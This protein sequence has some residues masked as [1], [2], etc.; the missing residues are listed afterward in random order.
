MEEEDTKNTQAKQKMNCESVELTNENLT[1]KAVMF[2]HS[3][4]V[5]QVLYLII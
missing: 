5:S 4:L 3:A 2:I 1:D